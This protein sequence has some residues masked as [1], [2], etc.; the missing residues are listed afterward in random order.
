MGAG[1]YLPFLKRAVVRDGP[2]VHLT[3]F[4]TGRCNARCRHCF[5]W[6]EVDAGVEGLAL[7]A[8]RRVGETVGGELL[9]LAFAGGEP[10]LRSDLGEIA[11]GFAARRPRHVS[12]PTNALVESTTVEG[13]ERVCEALPDAFVNVSVSFD[14]PAEIHDRI[15]A[16][17]GGFDRS[18]KTFAALKRLQA[19]RANLGIGAILTVTAENQAQA[20][21][22]VTWLRR[23]LAPDNVTINLARGGPR[24]AAL[25]NV[26][27][28]RYRAA[29]DAK[30]R[31]LRDG[32]LPYFRFPMARVAAA[33]DLVMYDRIEKQARGADDYRPCLAGRLSAV[34]YENGVVAPCEIRPDSFGNLHDVGY[35]FAR[36]WTSEEAQA[37]RDRI[38]AD[39]CACTWECQAGVNVLFTPSLYP[40]LA[41]RTL[42]R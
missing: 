35:D 40:K 38:W 2:P 9:W 37:I 5:H 10:F 31:D 42:A 21:D 26:D 7:E 3:V 29:V 34:I 25:L 8:M 22:F 23:E 1:S 17:P 24:D 39:Q 6:K 15:R 14:G 33:R 19:R 11:R 20:P 18:V 41:A 13:A 30:T 4:V 28:A 36:L 16:T 32:S 27:P 12:I